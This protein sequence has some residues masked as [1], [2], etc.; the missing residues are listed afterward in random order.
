MYITLFSVTLYDENNPDGFKEHGI[1][2]AKSYSDAALQIE[3]YYGNTLMNLEIA[4][5]ADSLL[6]YTS[7]EFHSEVKK[8]VDSIL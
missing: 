1:I 3:K 2:Y 8:I 4:Q 5:Y 7:N 6:T